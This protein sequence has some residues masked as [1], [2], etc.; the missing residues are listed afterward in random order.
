MLKFLVERRQRREGIIDM[1]IAQYGSAHRHA[2]LIALPLRE[3]FIQKCP[4]SA[5]ECPPGLDAGKVRGGQDD[6]LS[7]GNARH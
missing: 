4:E 7:A 6:A 5:I 3:L 2:L 1:L